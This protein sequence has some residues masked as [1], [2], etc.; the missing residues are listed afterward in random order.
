MD[1][2]A[3]NIVHNLQAEIEDLTARLRKVEAENQQLRYQQGTCFPLMELP[4]EIRILVWKNALPNRRV[5]R[6]SE[7]PASGYEPR[8]KMFCSARP[9]VLLH[10]CRESREVALAHFRPFFS[11]KCGSE[12]PRP[13]YF[14]PK[15]DILYIDVMFLDEITS[16]YPEV[17]EIESIAIPIRSPRNLDL[18]GKMTGMKS[19]FFVTALEEPWPWNRCCS[20]VELSPNPDRK[21]RELEWTDYISMIR[22]Y[23]R[24]FPNRPKVPNIEHVEAVVGKLSE[25][26]LRGTPSADECELAGSVAVVEHIVRPSTVLAVREF[27]KEAIDETL[28][29]FKRIRHDNIILA[30]E[31]FGGKS[32]YQAVESFHST[33]QV[34]R[35]LKEELESLDG[36]LQSLQQAVMAYGEELAGLNLPLLCC[37]KAC[38]EFEDIINKCATHS[39]DSKTSF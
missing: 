4:P 27:P 36:V 7:L 19:L 13:I 8:E 11:E 30:L 20:T 16:E 39:N 35:E 22:C 5:L 25:M 18:S 21:E 32:L 10:I 26:N 15:L 31:C 29:R 14:R 6:I 12:M 2:L 3:Q 1:L 37:G 34:V 23:E 38:R 28:D 33:K 17:N 9:P 24:N